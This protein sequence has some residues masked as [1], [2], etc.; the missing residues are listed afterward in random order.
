SHV[1]ASG[2]DAVVDS[3]SGLIGM[4]SEF[5]DDTGRYGIEFES[6]LDARLRI[7]R[8]VRLQARYL[9]VR[10]ESGI[11]ADAPVRLRPSSVRHIGDNRRGE[12]VTRVSGL[13]DVGIG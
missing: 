6:L 8:G 2:T 13:V 7:D 1:A 3:V 5:A 12:F 11:E 9:S 10:D 4:P